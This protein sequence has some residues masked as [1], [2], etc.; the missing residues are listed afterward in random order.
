MPSTYSNFLSR[1]LFRLELL[2]ILSKCPEKNHD[3]A[4]SIQD[5]VLPVRQNLAHMDQTLDAVWE[6]AEVAIADGTMSASWHSPT[7]DRW[8]SVEFELQRH[9]PMDIKVFEEENEENALLL[10]KDPFS[11]GKYSDFFRYILILP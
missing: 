7:F 9:T 6:E 10:T 11:K 4:V 8:L 1:A 3:L 2:K 5:Y